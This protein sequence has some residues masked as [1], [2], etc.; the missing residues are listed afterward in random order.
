MAR[1]AFPIIKGT[2]YPA[3]RAAQNPALLRS[4]DVLHVGNGKVVYRVIIG[5]NETN[6]IKVCTEANFRRAYINEEL[7]G[8][9]GPRSPKQT[10]IKNSPEAS[11]AWD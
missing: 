8:L 10:I 5:N 11:V 9:V 2:N 6:E 7:Q 4:A 1:N 3:R